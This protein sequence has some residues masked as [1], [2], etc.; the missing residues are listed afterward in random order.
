[1]VFTMTQINI[2][3]DTPIVD[4]NEFS[5][6][7]GLPLPTVR[8]MISQNQLPVMPRLERQKILINMVA[9][10]LMCA[11]QNDGLQKKSK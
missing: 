11:N 3:I 1:M 2:T 4:V 5:S 9:Y 7:T 8:R 6:R 10:T